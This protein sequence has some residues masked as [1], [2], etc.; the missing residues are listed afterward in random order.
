M[1]TGTAV[2]QVGEDCRLRHNW[3]T[4]CI[5]GIWRH[6]TQRRQSECVCKGVSGSGA[7]CPRWVQIA[8][9]GRATGP[10]AL[11]SRTDIVSVTTHVRKVPQADIDWVL[12]DGPRLDA[13]NGKCVFPTAPRERCRRSRQRRYEI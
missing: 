11:P 6:L 4:Q 10:S 9:S 7:A 8:K 1:M 2:W 5:R 3:S 13:I 12:P